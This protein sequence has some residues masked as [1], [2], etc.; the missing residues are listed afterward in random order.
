MAKFRQRLT[1]HAKQ[2]Q[3]LGTFVGDRSILIATAC[4]IVVRTLRKIHNRGTAATRFADDPVVPTRW[5]VMSLPRADASVRRRASKKVS[6]R[7]GFRAEI[8]LQRAAPR[9]RARS[10]RNA[11]RTAGSSPA[12]RR[13]VACPSPTVAHS[14]AHGAHFPCQPRLGEIPLSLDGGGET[15]TTSAVSSM[16]RPRRIAAPRFALVWDRT[17]QCVERL[18]ERHDV[19]RTLNH[20]QNSLL[21]RNGIDAPPR[22]AAWRRRL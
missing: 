4:R 22:L 5:P 3:D 18:V 11:G 20:R 17:C 7:R 14:L 16:L 8:R 6:A 15:P 10:R 21:E 1:L 19:G 2:L 13:R 12:P 9:R